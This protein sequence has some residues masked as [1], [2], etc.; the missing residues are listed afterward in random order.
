MTGY[1]SV[2][3]I[4]LNLVSYILNELSNKE[5]K[6]FKEHL[7]VCKSCRDDPLF[8]CIDPRIGM[9]VDLYGTGELEEHD[10]IKVEKHLICC[11]ACLQYFIEKSDLYS[12]LRKKQNKLRQ[13]LSQNPQEIL[14]KIFKLLK[15]HN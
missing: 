13:W 9:M 3:I 10:K 14:K 1:I 15:N 8:D 5:T 12:F 7:R 4:N 11:D 2:A 6:K